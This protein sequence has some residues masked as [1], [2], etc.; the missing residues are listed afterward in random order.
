MNNTDY[1]DFKPPEAYKRIKA[2]YDQMEDSPINETTVNT[3]NFEENPVHKFHKIRLEIDLIEND[4]E[5]YSNNVYKILLKK[6]LFQ[7]KYSIERSFNELRNLKVVT[8]YVLSSENYCL[9]NEIKLKNVKMEKESYKLLN[10]RIYEKLNE[11]LLH[12]VKIINKLKSE[13]IQSF[14]NVEYELYLT[15]DTMKLKLFT[16]MIEIKKAIQNM[17]QKIGLWDL[18]RIY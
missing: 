3:Q 16:R 2:H 15:P 13:N 18:V 4:L 7:D 11:H 6:E 5:F 8:D 12:K 10:F 17:E 1:S 9:M 14:D